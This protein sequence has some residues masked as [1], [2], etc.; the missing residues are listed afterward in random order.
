MLE[1]LHRRHKVAG[2]LSLTREQRDYLNVGTQ[3]LAQLAM[4]GE[5]PANPTG[6]W[7]HVA[8]ANTSGPM[9]TGSPFG[10]GRFN[11]GL[12]HGK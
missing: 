6:G 2:Y 1:K 9:L 12:Y 11:V 5:T 4:L 7:V 8:P 3:A 10:E